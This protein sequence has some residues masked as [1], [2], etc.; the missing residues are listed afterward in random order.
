MARETM[1]FS[2]QLNRVAEQEMIARL[3]EVLEV[4]YLT[5]EELQAFYEELM[6][7]PQL[8]CTFSARKMSAPP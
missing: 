5:N 2:D 6:R 7:Q 3:E 8:L 1:R 4:N